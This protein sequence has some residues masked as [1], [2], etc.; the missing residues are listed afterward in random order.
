MT[1][2]INQNG[3]TVCLRHGGAYLQSAV[4]ANPRLQEVST[5]LD[6]WVAFD[7]S[8]VSLNCEDCS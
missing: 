6:H 5:P 3:R 7:T 1:L 4:G 8:E 2:F